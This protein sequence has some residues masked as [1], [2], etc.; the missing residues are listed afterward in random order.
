MSGADVALIAT[1]VGTATSV[2]GSIKQGQ[3]AQSAAKFNSQVASNNAASARA[4][5]SE[6]ALRERRDALRRQG[7]IRARSG[8][9]APLDLLEDQVMEDE[10]KVLSILHEGDIQAGNYTTQASLERQRGR[11]AK[12]AATFSA[13]GSLLKGASTGAGQYDKLPPNSFLKV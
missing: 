1:A 8:A 5:A 6:N 13:A 9:G 11:S 7:A 2:V 3:A 12:Q 4:T 10:L